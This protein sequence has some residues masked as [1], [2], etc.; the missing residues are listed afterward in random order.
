[1]RSL[2]FVLFSYRSK[3]ALNTDWKFDREEVEGAGGTWDMGR[4]GKRL[5]RRDTESTRNPAALVLPRPGGGYAMKSFDLSSDSAWVGLGCVQRQPLS[6][7]G[8]GS[9]STSVIMNS[10]TRAQ[11]NTGYS[12][13][14]DNPSLIVLPWSFSI[15]FICQSCGASIMSKL[16]EQYG[17]RGAFNHRRNTVLLL[18]FYGHTI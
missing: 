2:F 1:V 11:A 3:A 9:T 12:L 18:Q 6:I 10:A 16:R 7:T 13:V 15:E 4:V 8:S 5:F 17:S 14:V